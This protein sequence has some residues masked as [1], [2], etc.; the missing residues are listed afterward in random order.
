MKELTSLFR[1]IW[2]EE[3]IPLHWGRVADSTH[4]QEGNMQVLVTVG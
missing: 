2:N 4:L 1:G 3:G